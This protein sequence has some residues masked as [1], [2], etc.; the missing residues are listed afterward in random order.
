ML[1]QVSSPTPFK[2]LIGFLEMF[3]QEVFV[4]SSACF[5]VDL[6]MTVR[7]QLSTVPMLL[8]FQLLS[9]QETIMEMLAIT[10]LLEHLEQSLLATLIQ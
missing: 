8:E 10:V 4:V 6:L 3:P 7:M 1:V 2:E 5:L 9:L